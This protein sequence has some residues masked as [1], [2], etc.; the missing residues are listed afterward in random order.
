MLT[1]LKYGKTDNTN[2][3]DKEYIAIRGTVIEQLTCSFYYNK[4]YELDVLILYLSEAYIVTV[5]YS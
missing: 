4:T 3:F 2:K 5:A 1:N